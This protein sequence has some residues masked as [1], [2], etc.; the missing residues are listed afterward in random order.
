[1]KICI[2]SVLT[3]RENSN[4][5]VRVISDRKVVYKNQETYLTP[6]TQKLLKINFVVEP[7]KY[8]C[9]KN[10]LLEDYL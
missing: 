3:F 4:I 8:W 7:T 6:L 5:T 1:M 9:Y 10:K 2:G